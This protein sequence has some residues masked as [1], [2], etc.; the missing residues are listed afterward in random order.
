MGSRDRPTHRHTR[1]P[2]RPGERGRVLAP[3]ASAR[4]RRPLSDDPSSRPLPVPRPAPP[5]PAIERELARA[6]E[7]AASA[8]APATRRAY[9]LVREHAPKARNK[10][11]SASVTDDAAQ[12]FGARR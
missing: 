9:E 11:L 4:Q 2:H 6:S 1:G 12:R 3:R 8:L 5:A 7:Y 10:W